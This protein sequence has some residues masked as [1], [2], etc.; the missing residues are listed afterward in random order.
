MRLLKDQLVPDALP[1]DTGNL[2]AG[3]LA[4]DLKIYPYFFSGNFLVS[5]FTVILTIPTLFIFS[6]FSYSRET[7]FHAR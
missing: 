5:L 7:H 4:A 1:Y 2:T 6:L 3:I